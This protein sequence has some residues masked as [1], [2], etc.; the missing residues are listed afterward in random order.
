MTIEFISVL[1]DDSITKQ[2]MN[3][4]DNVGTSFMQ[5]DEAVREVIC[6]FTSTESVTSQVNK[7]LSNRG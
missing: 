7:G 2:R 1:I 5:A 3:V 6:E 4:K